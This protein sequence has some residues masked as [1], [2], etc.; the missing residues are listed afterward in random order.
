MAL[1]VICL[2][3]L[4]GNKVRCISRPTYGDMALKATKRAATSAEGLAMRGLR[5][6][7]NA[8]K[9]KGG[10]IIIKLPKLGHI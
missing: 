2:E 10:G 9:E 5:E 3:D 6:I 8:S 1:V 7:A 4:P